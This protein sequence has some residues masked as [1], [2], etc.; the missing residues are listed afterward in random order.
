M[1]RPFGIQI[2]LT[3][4]LALQLREI[5]AYTPGGVARL[6]AEP[7]AS[8][9][10]SAAAAGAPA[11]SGE[12]AA[13]G[14]TLLR[15]ANPLARSIVVQDEA[16]GQLLGSSRGTELV[17]RAPRGTRLVVGCGDGVR[18]VDGVVFAR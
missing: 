17:I 3:D 8:P 2:P 6:V 16:S 5:R 9:G 4:D 13:N 18:N 12:P 11:V 15:C 1:D 10:A 14:G 7:G